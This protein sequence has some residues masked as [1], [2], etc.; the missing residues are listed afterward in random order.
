[1]LAHLFGQKRLAAP[2]AA[3][4]AQVEIGGAKGF[5][6][7]LQIARGMAAHVVDG[8]RIEVAPQRGADKAHAAQHQRVALQQ[9][10]AELLAGTLQTLVGFVEIQSVVFMVAGNEDH[11][12]RPMR[13]LRQR[14]KALQTEMLVRQA[15]ALL[16]RA[17][18][19]RE[20]QHIRAGGGRGHEMRVGFQ[21]QVG[22]Q[23]DLHGPLDRS[24]MS[25][26]GASGLAVNAALP[27]ADFRC[28]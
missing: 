27:K 28:A 25:S 26:V 14:R 5:F 20:H 2:R 1:M 22:E 24:E 19:A 16:V 13:K 12:R 21:M 10:D 18:V 7:L 17:H 6:P 11:R 9:V 23:L 4:L 15:R 8:E 3:G